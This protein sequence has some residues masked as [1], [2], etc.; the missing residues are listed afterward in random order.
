M[1]SI[2]VPSSTTDLG[3]GELHTPDFALVAQAVL[4]DGLQFRVT[5]RG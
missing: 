2:N 4:A 3:Q 1:R 5:R